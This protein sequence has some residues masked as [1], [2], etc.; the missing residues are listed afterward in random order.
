MTPTGT[1]TTTPFT[2]QGKFQASY[3]PAGTIGNITYTPGGTIGNITYTPEG[4]VVVPAYSPE[5]TVTINYTPVGTI[6]NIT[7]TPK[8]GVST[9]YTPQ[10][11]VVSA[12]YTPSGD[13]GFTVPAQ[14][15]LSVQVE[16]IKPTG[17]VTASVKV[18]GHTH[19]ATLS[20]TAA[21]ITG[22]PTPMP[23]P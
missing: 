11:T 17:S 15:G 12:S 13:I 16:E 23:T 19:T 7:Y 14:N 18:P 5:G 4:N 21:T 8:G 9:T 20:G 10:A 1:I 6:G 3:K 2:P 22:K